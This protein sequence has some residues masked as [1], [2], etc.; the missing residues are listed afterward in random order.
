MCAQR[1]RV[2]PCPDAK[3]PI[4]RVAKAVAW[5]AAAATA[6]G[7]LLVLQT[8]VGAPQAQA[9]AFKNGWD[10]QF[11]DDLLWYQLTT[12]VTT[13]DTTNESFAWRN[14]DQIAPGQLAKPLSQMSIWRDDDGTA[15]D[16]GII[17][18]AAGPALLKAR[19]LQTNALVGLDASGKTTLFWPDSSSGRT[20]VD[21]IAYGKLSGAQVI[22]GVPDQTAC[23]LQGAH[24]AA[25]NQENGY[26]YASSFRKMTLAGNK[27]DAAM[28]LGVYEL[29]WAPG[30]KTQ[31]LRCLSAVNTMTAAGGQT[32]NQQWTEATGLAGPS[33]HIWHLSDDTVVDMQGNFYLMATGGPERHAL[34]K[35]EVPYQADGTPYPGNRAWEYSL[36]KAFTAEA[37]PR[38]TPISGMAFL[39][40]QIYT[41]EDASPPVLRRWDPLAGTMTTLGKVSAEPFSKAVNQDL[42]GSQPA[43]TVH[44]T[45]YNDANGNGAIDPGESGVGGVAVEIWQGDA[46]SGSTNWTHRLTLATDAA[47]AYSTLVNAKD[48]EYLIRLARPRIG[49]ANARQTYASAGQYSANEDQAGQD[50]ANLVRPYCASAGGDYQER[51]GSGP[52]W[53]ARMDGAEPAAVA[54]PLDPAAGAAI[55]TNVKARTAR[56][57]TVADFGLTVA[58]SWGDAPEAYLTTNAAAGPHANPTR[59]GQP[60]L[61]LGAA[62]GVYP[63][64]QPKSD[65]DAHAADDGL[66]IAPVAPGE[67]PADDAWQSAQGQLMAAGQ[68][69]AF[70]ARAAVPAEL[71]G[72]AQ[73]KAWI[74]AAT[75]AGPSATMG[76]ALLGAGGAC[77]PTPDQ[78]GLVTCDFTATSGSG[79]G[80]VTPLYARARISTDPAMTAV[81]RGG[82]QVGESW[83]PLGEIED[84]QLGVATGVVRIQA[85][86][87]GGVAA[88]VRLALD[89]ANISDVAPSA[90]TDTVA[91]SA[92]GGFEGSRRG[93]AVK[94]LSQ[95]VVITTA[96]VG[97]ADATGLNGWRLAAGAQGAQNQDTHCFD[98]LTGQDLGAQVDAAAGSVTLAPTAGDL[99]KDV[100]CRLTYVPAADLAQSTVTADPSGN[101][102][103]SDRLTVPLG[104]SQ[105]TVTARGSVQDANGDPKTAPATGDRAELALAP[106][107]GAP[108]AGARFETSGDGGATWNAGGQ[109]LT[110][111]L[112]Q[113]GACAEA[114]RVV[115]QAPGGYALSARIGGRHLT[116]PATG[117]PTDASPV[118]IWFKAGAPASGEIDLADTKDRAA[119]HGQASPA[120]SY[121][122]DIW[123]KD[124]AGHGVTGLTDAN[125]TKHCSTG[126]RPV[127][128][129]AAAGVVFGQ[130]T[131]DPAAAG[132]YTVAVAATKAGEKWLAIAAA[133]VP[134][135]LP[136]RGQPAQQHVTATFTA[137]A[138]ADAAASSFAVTSS[139]QRVAWASN[140]DDPA[141]Y[142]TGQVALKDANANPITGARAKLAWASAEPAA[143][144]VEIAESGQAGVYDVKI[145]SAAPGAFQG[146]KITF[147]Q[148]GAA[149]LTL[150]EAETLVFTPG[151]PVQSASSMTIT[152]TAGQAA[153]FGA[154][155]ATAA[156]WGKQTITVTLR[157]QSGNAYQGG[158]GRLFARSPKTGAEGVH[159]ADPAGVGAGGFACAEAPGPDGCQGGVYAL[160]V[161]AS[162]A[163][164]KTIAVGFAPGPEPAFDVLEQGTGA[165]FVTAVFTTPPARAADSVFVLG[166]PKTSPGETDPQDNWDDPADDP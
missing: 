98:S 103:M 6:L 66:E 159:Y 28:K 45:V 62:A 104:S 8:A 43:A 120:D 7:G 84:Y 33:D 133:G 73:V 64:G 162:L 95:P 130:V 106:L 68:T 121:N 88:H 152:K 32:L 160:D 109:T 9:V 2:R 83:A 63:D 29:G 101:Q 61:H 100:T 161:H 86:S 39:D 38:A 71:A 111:A 31:P 87:L 138:E 122:L 82:G 144:R 91:T 137:M 75:A 52:C 69:Y 117:Q 55:V 96:A 94:S 15:G 78:N 79:T 60:Y 80:A 119:N 24:S 97:A 44:G 107:D 147:A 50:P 17:T 146:L 124:G 145:W 59:A 65:A 25:I 19:G 3:T 128:C 53:G 131:E 158:V 58:G 110:C 157:D 41:I 85:R 35:V 126:G 155:G 136:K 67:R 108:S 154:P 134:A 115:G 4:G 129:P 49:G 51:T 12:N 46:A 81:S 34:I 151:Q 54:N 10:G 132:H 89:G 163:G 148:P 143:D 156:T 11:T 99:P 140:Q 123:V 74:T 116:N 21:A 14:P 26:L 118:E 142:H 165:A 92:G 166:D 27:A 149:K 18:L 76:Q 139:G 113:A 135:A 13:H 72:A 93:H 141:Y 20:K 114:V 16:W 56:A 42:A 22:P 153:N 23:Y 57:A 77:S 70:R 127:A 48:S 112:D 1:A 105:V 150:T 36:V 40:G 37:N 90:V 164:A 102:S 30:A 5:T 125:F 47:G